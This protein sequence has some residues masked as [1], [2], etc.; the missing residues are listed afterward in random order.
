MAAN[1]TRTDAA[2][3]ASARNRSARKAQRLAY[4]AHVAA[5]PLCSSCGKPSIG[6]VDARPFC[7][8]CMAAEVSA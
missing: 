1:R 5:Q 2:T 3:A 4:A 8:R 7:G 6:T